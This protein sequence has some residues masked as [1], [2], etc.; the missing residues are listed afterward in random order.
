[1][2]EVKRAFRADVAIEHLAHVQ[3]ES[4]PNQRRTHSATLVIAGCS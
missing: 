2:S 4:E 3:R 1:V